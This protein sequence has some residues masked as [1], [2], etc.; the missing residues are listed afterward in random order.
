VEHRKVREYITFLFV[1]LCRQPPSKDY[2]I[3]HATCKPH[4]NVQQRAG[5]DGNVSNPQKLR[6]Y[7]LLPR[8]AGQPKRSHHAAITGSQSATDLSGARGERRREKDQE[9]KAPGD[10]GEG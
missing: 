7:P 2:K 1:E 9:K 6:K 3:I 4:A 5:I 10:Y 8:S